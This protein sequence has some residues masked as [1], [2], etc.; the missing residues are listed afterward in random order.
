MKAVERRDKHGNLVYKL[1]AYVGLDT[2]GKKKIVSTTWKPDPT[3][4][5]RKINEELKIAQAKFEIHAKEEAER[6]KEEEFAKIDSA[7]PFADFA[8]IFINDYARITLKKSTVNDYE[9]R[10][11]RIN[12]AI[13]HI[14]LEKFTP[15]V[16]NKF[17]ANLSEPGI[18]LTSKTPQGLSPKTVKNYKIL[19]SAIFTKA[20]EWQYLSQSPM[21]MGIVIPKV[22]KSKIKPLTITEAQQLL[23]LLMEEAPLKY[24]VFFLTDLVTGARRGELCGLTWDDIDFENRIISIRRNLLYNVK[25]GIYVDT[26]KTE[27]SY[28]DNRVSEWLIDLYRQLRTEQNEKQQKKAVEWLEYDFVFRRDDGQPTHP[29]SW[30]TWFT[31]FQETH[32]FRKTTIHELRHTTATLLIGNKFNSKMVAGRLGHGSTK[33]TNDIYADYLRDSDEAVNDEMDTLLFQK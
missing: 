30:A 10:L 24:Q 17:L 7:I 9:G 27:Q 12:E 28:R 20:V 26:L 18:K 1:R 25:D 8:K 33:T 32:N 15:V 5:K 2:R 29:N 21:E 4:S 31:R 23:N 6:Q 22:T 19:L 14:P 3:W 16:I 13:G 11:K